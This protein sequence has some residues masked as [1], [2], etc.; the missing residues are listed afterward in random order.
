[1]SWIKSARRWK[2]SCTDANG[3]TRT[4]GYFDTQ[5]EAA[6]AYNAAIR[7]LPPAIQ[8]RRNRNPVVDGQLVPRVRK[9]AGHGQKASYKRRREESG[10][11]PSTRAH[12]PRRAAAN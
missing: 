12:R 6:H 8:R 5:E 11:A 10:V 1:M 9:A 7:A 3:K 2:A 4:I